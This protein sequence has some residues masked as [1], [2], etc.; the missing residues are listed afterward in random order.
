MY[1]LS[2]RNTFLAAI[3]TSLPTKEGQPAHVN[4][5][6]IIAG[7]LAAA[8]TKSIIAPLN[9]LTILMQS[10]GLTS[11]HHAN[12]PTYTTIGTSF[13]D[14]VQKEGVRALWNGNGTNVLRVIP[15]YGLRF[16][17]NDIAREF[18]VRFYGLD[19]TT[20][21]HSMT[22]GQLLLSSSLAAIVQI[23][24]TYPIEVIS[25]RLTVSGSELSP[26]R[27]NGIID[28]LTRTVRQEGLGS[29]YNGYPITLLAGTPYI[30]L[31]MS[32]FEI[33]QRYFH[34]LS[35][36]TSISTK[37]ITNS[38]G[39]AVG[40]DKNKNNNNNNT[41]G[42]VPK[43]A[44]GALASLTAQTITYPGDVLRRR[45][46]VDGMGS[47]RRYAY[48]NIVHATKTIWRTEGWKAFFKGIHVNS[49]RI[50]PEGA[51]MFVLVDV[52]KRGLDI[53]KYD[54]H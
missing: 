38:G 51:I 20:T 14:M 11:L 48:K 52:F 43:L 3:D 42:V 31:Q 44:A 21:R 10:Q 37:D 25:T 40:D 13:R 2:H 1:A 12:A 46:Q 45:M 5:Y 47:E 27:Y 22:H 28:C 16:A 39:G 35:Q 49:L 6:R 4:T 8:T 29:V 30:A 33:Y 50:L 24:L 17:L 15:N 19:P 54:T 26:V 36:K 41:I 18:V 32:C 53:E 23:T 34:E 7:G 9:R